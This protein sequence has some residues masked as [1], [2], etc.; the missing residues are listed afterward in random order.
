MANRKLYSEELKKANALLD[1]V[2]ERLREL[3]A[4]D[5]ELLFAYRRKVF[6]ELSY[7]ERS[8]PANRSKLKAQKRRE[9]EGKCPLCGNPLPK[10]YCVLDRHIASAGYS[11]ANTRLICQPCDV[12]TQGQRGYR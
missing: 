10:T 12:E 2:R 9:Q 11:A 1:D 4:G 6:K 7:D 5:S 8:K 3:S